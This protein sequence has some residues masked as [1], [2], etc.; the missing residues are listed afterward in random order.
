ME[1]GSL[2]DNPYTNAGEA[3]DKAMTEAKRVVK[4]LKKEVFPIHGL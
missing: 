2:F 1:V 4:Y 3:K